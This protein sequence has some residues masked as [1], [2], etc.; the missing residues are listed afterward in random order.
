LAAMGLGT[1]FSL[2]VAWLA[3]RY[4]FTPYLGLLGPYPPWTALSRS[5]RRVRGRA[6]M[7]LGY[8]SVPL[9]LWLALGL[10]PI[11]L[12]GPPL[13]RDIAAIALAALAWPLL[14]ASLLVAMEPDDAARTVA[15][16]AP[17]LRQ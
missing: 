11:S 17:G 15:A 10:L 12:P 8:V 6:W 5:A 3:L 9:T 2:P 13:L 14:H 4:L 16:P 7:L 1:L